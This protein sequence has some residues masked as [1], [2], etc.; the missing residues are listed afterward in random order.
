[1]PET[2]LNF[3]KD[4]VDRWNAHDLDS[5]YGALDENYCEYFNGVFVKRGGSATRA[6]D[7]FIYDSVPDYRREVDELYADQ[8]GGAMRWRFCGTGPNGPF[9]ISFASTYRINGGKIVE[10]WLYG[11]PTAYT[12]AFGLET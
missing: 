12:D 2:Q 11:D 6:A 9:E 10:C 4:L 1:M 5:A 7:Q 8:D 3:L